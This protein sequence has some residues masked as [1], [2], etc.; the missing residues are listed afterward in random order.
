MLESAIAALNTLTKSD[1]TEVKALKNPP[2]VVKLV[3]EAVC[4]MLS[5]KPKRIND[6]NDPV[7]KI[8]NYWPVADT[9]GGREVPG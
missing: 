5:M 2:A 9:P 1:I 7:R 3:M 6:P 4:H 8:Y